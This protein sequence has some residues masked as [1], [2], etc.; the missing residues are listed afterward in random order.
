M[1][2]SLLIPTVND[3]KYIDHLQRKNAEDLAFYPFVALEKALN[4]QH[5]IACQENDEIAGYLWFGAVRE[6][7]DLIIFQACVDYSAR[8]RLLG[9]AMVNH[10]LE[11]GKVGKCN[12]IRLKC[13]SSS[14]SNEFWKSIGF[15]CTEV[16]PGGIK[17]KRDLNVYR[18]DI[19][20]PLIPFPIV[21]PSKKATDE[22][23]YHRERR[24]K[25]KLT[26]PSRFSRSHY[27]IIDESS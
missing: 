6:G 17:R 18:T 26:M 1:N 2:N 24:K 3:L 7:Y 4:T 13:A 10:L 5:I 11:L 12:G 20:S 14:E 19:I 16:T 25:D 8:R 22:T 27:G 23:S 9:Y 15:Y 21:I